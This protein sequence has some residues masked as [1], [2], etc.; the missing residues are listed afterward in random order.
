MAEDLVVRFATEAHFREAFCSA[1]SFRL[2]RAGVERSRSK[3][4]GRIYSSI[5]V[6]CSRTVAA[7]K[8]I[9]CRLHNI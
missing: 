2:N 7:N 9:R 4:R 6:M 8:L 3:K 5:E 1:V